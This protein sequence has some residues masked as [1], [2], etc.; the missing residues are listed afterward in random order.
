MGTIKGVPNIG[1][2]YYTTKSRQ[3][4]FEKTS[5]D[6]I[7]FFAIAYVIVISFSIVACI[8]FDNVRNKVWM[9]CLGVFSTGLAVLGSFGLLLAMGVPFV[10]TV[11]TSPF[12][13][14]GIGVDDMFIMISSWQQTN[15][16]DSVPER[17]S[18]TFETAA[19]SITIT[20]LTDVL[21]FFLSYS[22]P[23]GSVQSFCLYTGTAV[24]FCYIYNVTFFGACLALNGQREESNRHW[25]TCM[26]VPEQ[27]PQG[28]S[29]A[30]GV[31][32]VGG[33]YDHDTGTEVE[34]PIQKFLR[35]YYGPCLVSTWMRVFVC[36]L[37]AVYLAVAIYGC[38]TIKEG[39]DLGNLANDES[40]IH[41]YYKSE[42]TYFSE[43]GPMVMLAVKD[44]YPY[45][46]EGARLRLD[47]CIEHFH[48]LTEVNPTYSVSWLQSFEEFANNTQGIVNSE[49]TFTESLLS[50]LDRDP[51][52][53]EDLKL[54]S[55]NTIYASRFFLQTVNITSSEKEKKMLENFRNTR[56]D[57]QLS[58]EVYHPTFIYYDQYVVITAITIQTVVVVAVVMLII[59][60][61]LIPSPF[62]ALWVT[63]AIAS[64]IMGVIGFMTYCGVSLDS[65]SM[66]NLII[67]IGFA[68][69][70]SAHISYAFVSSPKTNANEKVVEALSSLG[71]PILQG[72]L[73]TLAGIVVLSVS[74][75]YIFRTFFVIMSLVILFGLL[76]G[77]A[78]IPVFLSFLGTCS[79]QKTESVTH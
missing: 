54:S 5:N 44:T 1:L 12:L 23:F 10:S 63:F 47:M 24:L 28:G 31:C 41:K 13:I 9:A 59:S 68:V 57:C 16:R 34:S 51:M 43:Y 26:K 25:F 27:P 66:I 50:F 78:F 49:A 77:V 22:N 73:S 53:R 45:W 36:L 55:N 46:E 76:H 64:V 62:C 42:K 75:S 38:V 35:Q 21:A 56:N 37:Y 6:V 30:S 2:S 29:R 3:E 14:L 71:Y 39:I 20:T 79:K 60:L 19:I 52:F 11:G 74:R 70:Y 7:I 17:L 4:E 58:V 40:Y 32:C 67:C 8:R 18:H 72:A 61:L 69:D 33:T 65:I 48:N 15:V